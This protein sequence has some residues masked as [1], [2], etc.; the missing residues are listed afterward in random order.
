MTNAKAE[1]QA[2][3]RVFAT[4]VNRVK[5]IAGRFFLELVKQKQVVKRQLVKIGNVIDHPALKQL[6]NDLWTEAV[7]IHCISRSKVRQTF[8]HQCLA[9]RI[10][11]AKRCF[12]IQMHKFCAAFRTI[13]RNFIWF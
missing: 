12:I 3:K 5:Q 7:D 8:F 10:D 4:C 6:F 9:L 11:A 13:R 1:Q 2:F